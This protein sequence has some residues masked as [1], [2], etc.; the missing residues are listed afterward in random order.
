[1]SPA[2]SENTHSMVIGYVVWILGFFG[3]HRFYFGRP[4]SGTIWFFTLGLLFVGWIIDL[5]LIPGMVQVE[6]LS[7]QIRLQSQPQGAS[8]HLHGAGV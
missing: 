3:A 1:M 5:F 2:S 7:R 8:G 6:N 4:I